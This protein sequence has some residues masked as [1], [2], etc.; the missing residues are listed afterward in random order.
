MHSCCCSPSILIRLSADE[1]IAKFHEM[2]VDRGVSALASWERA[3]DLTMDDPR[4]TLLPPEFRRT[5]FEAWAS[6]NTER[7]R[8]AR[9]ELTKR[10]QR[11]L[12]RLL[13]EHVRSPDMTFAEFS[14]RFGKD[15]IFRSVDKPKVR[16]DLFREHS[17]RL[18]DMAHFGER[19]FRHR[20][21]DEYRRMLKEMSELHGNSSWTK[22]KPILE[23]DPRF[24]SVA[25]SSERED[26]F[27]DHVD[28]LYRRDRDR[29][30]E[31]VKAA[32]DPEAERRR[33]AEEALRERQKQVRQ[34]SWAQQ[35]TL[36]KQ[37]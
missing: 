23:D 36:D 27:R 18:R 4:F 3:K 1:R 29:D 9:A 12:R 30:R 14:A 24:W 32:E 2:L 34:Q 15:P 7:E 25:S 19:E 26:L 5:E 6:A 13:V 35:R 28:D 22:T 17:K 33:R 20:A 31:R 37:R 10:A 21:R 11:E 16:E 8:Q